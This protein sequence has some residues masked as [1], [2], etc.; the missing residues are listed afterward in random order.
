MNS[1]EK[2][3]ST[4]EANGNDQST[5]KSEP[6][7]E[8]YFAVSL[9]KLLLMSLCTGGVYEI[10]WFYKNWEI[11]RQ[12]EKIK[13]MPVWRSLFAYFFCY[14]LFRRISYSEKVILTK[15][16]F[17]PGALTIGWVLL[18]FSW[19]L[20]GAY[21]L[22]ANLAVLFILPAQIAVNEI[23]SKV[24]PDHNKNDTYSFWNV[25]IIALGGL[26]LILSV[27]GAFL[28]PGH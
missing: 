21:W 2:N 24:A 13:I 6:Q 5:V 11:V 4:P 19:K 1:E 27:G 26:I 20:P 3:I 16:T 7:T 10:F 15:N 28:G 12:R 18:T 17:T 22:L 9:T 8:Y 14:A 25:L 23:N